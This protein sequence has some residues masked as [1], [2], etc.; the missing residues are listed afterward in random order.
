MSFASIIS[1]TLGL[2]CP[3]RVPSDVPNG[4]VTAGEGVVS[5]QADVPTRGRS[6]MCQQEVGVV[7]VQTDVPTR[8]R[9]CSVQADV[10]TRGR[11][12]FSSG[13]CANKR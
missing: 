7:S 2:R 3:R 1:E 11:S 5:V 10:P 13:R 8:G 4:D 9:S 6:C 12:C